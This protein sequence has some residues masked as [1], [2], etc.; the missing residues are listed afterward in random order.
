MLNLKR[1]QLYRTIR[2]EEASNLIRS[3]NSSSSAGLPISFTKMIFSLSNDVTA[4]SAFGGRHKDR[5]E[6]FHLADMLPSVKLLEMLS[7][8]TSETKR[9]HEKADK[10]FANIINDHRACKAMGEA[11]ALVNVLLDIEEHVD[12]QCPLTTDNIKA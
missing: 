11:H 7:G 8:M 10:I 1:V 5:G 2:V 4:R 12:V 3:I 9:M 6:V